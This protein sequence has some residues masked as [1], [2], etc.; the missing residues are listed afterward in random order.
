MTSRA[1]TPLH[2]RSNAELKLATKSID[3]RAIASADSAT[4]AS[5]YKG[6]RTHT[7]DFHQVKPRVQHVAYQT[8]ELAKLSIRGIAFMSDTTKETLRGT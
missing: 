6:N 2:F 7:L 5:R 3:P 4:I 1:T 8:R